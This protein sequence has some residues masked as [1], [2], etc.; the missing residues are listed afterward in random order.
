[1]SKADDGGALRA[2]AVEERSTVGGPEAH[3]AVV[4]GGREGEI[5]RG[6]CQGAQGFLGG[7][8]GLPGGGEGGIGALERFRRRCK[9]GCCGGQFAGDSG[10]GKRRQPRFRLGVGARQRRGLELRFRLL[11]RLGRFVGRLFGL[12]IGGE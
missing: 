2:Y 3:Q 9:C 4:G 6:E 10:R 1:E 12:R 7:R 11:Q 8:D 5:V